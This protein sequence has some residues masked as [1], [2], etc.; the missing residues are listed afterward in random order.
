MKLCKIIRLVSPAERPGIKFLFEVK[1]FN[2]H[3]A[4][5]NSPTIQMLP[6]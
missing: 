3:P 6:Q 5:P 2:P 4:S 1:M